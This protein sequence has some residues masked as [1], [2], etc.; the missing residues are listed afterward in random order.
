VEIGA[1][2]IDACRTHFAL[3][4]DNDRLH[5]LHADGRDFIAGAA[6]ASIDV[7][8]VDAYDA[9]VDGPALD[10]ERFYAACHAALRPGGTA[11]INLV[12]QALDVSGSVGRI[13]AH[14]RPH[15]V[16][17]FPPSEGGNVVVIAHAGPAPAEDVL[18]ARAT[19]IEKRWDLPASGW[20]AMARRSAGPRH[21]GPT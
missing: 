8:Q 3:P 9:D 15:A 7:L 19:E 13:R 1:D 14:L 5:V 4:P 16:W 18:A 10:S 20:V 6:Q 21:A 2:V 12:G 17:Q 11:C